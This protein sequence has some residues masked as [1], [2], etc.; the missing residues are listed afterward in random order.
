[1]RE[2]LE[3]YDGELL[4]HVLIAD[5]R[6]LAVAWFD[7]GSTDPMQRLLAVL[8]AGLAEGDERVENA[9]AVSFVEDAAWWDQPSQAFI[10]TWPAG[11]AHEVERQRN[12]RS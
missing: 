8:D 4:L 3:T 10:A 9:V 1:M 6:R 11:L 12:A 2:H 5:L 7:E